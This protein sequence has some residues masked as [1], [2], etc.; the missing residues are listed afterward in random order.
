MPRLEE[1][2]RASG[3]SEHVRFVG[4]V[5]DVRLHLEG[6]DIGVLS[7]LSE[8][9]P[10]AILEY[11]AMGLPIVATEVGGTRELL[12]EDGECGFLVP[13]GQPA[14]LATR[15]FE[16]FT[17]PVSR[18]RMGD[19][20]R[21]RAERMFDARHMAQQYGQLFDRLALGGA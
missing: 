14:P 6:S 5:G 15:L 8:G 12:G 16:L 19:R 3:I 17:D 9:L 7:S 13:A 20:G 10:N 11:M 4:E 2:A 1:R 18:A 21:I